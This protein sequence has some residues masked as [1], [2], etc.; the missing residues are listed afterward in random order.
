MLFCFT[1]SI[2]SFRLPIS[3]SRDL[4]FS[5]FSASVVLRFLFKSF[6]CLSDSFSVS[7]R[8]FFCSLIP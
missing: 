1:C 4:F 2:V 8:S 5:F 7:L 3:V 6:C